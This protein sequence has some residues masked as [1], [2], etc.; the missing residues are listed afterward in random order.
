MYKSMLFFVSS[1]SSPLFLSSAKHT[2][3]KENKK[4][5]TMPKILFLIINHSPTLN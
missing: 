3:V 5:K 1:Y 2:E 4:I